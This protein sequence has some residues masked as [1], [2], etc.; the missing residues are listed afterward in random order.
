MNLE[1]RKISS[2]IEETLIEGGRKAEQP[3]K[4]VVVAAVLRNPWAGQGFVNDLKPEIL[5][6]APEL[7]AIMIARLL[8]LMP[9]DRIKAYGKAASVGTNGEI[10][11]GAGL[12]HTLRF[13]NLYREAVNGTTYL[14]F[15]N[16]R[17]APAALL[18]VPMTHKSETGK[19]SHFI[20]VNFSI[21]DAPGPDEILIAI[22]ASDGGRV[23]PRIGDRFQDMA[24]ME[25]E[26]NR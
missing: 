14:A 9:S 12:I 7:G 1:L 19:R 5:R 25:A 13:G 6:V 8:A 17:N 10:E 4:M 16:T 11:H 26:G 18:S 24:E 23:H 22:A 3:V 20:T 2:F 21:P 15:A